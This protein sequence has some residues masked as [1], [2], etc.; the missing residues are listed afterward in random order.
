MASATDKRRREVLRAIVSDYIASQEPVG[1]KAL[2]ERHELNVSSATIRNDMAV[3][4]SEGFIAQ[5]HASSGR[6]PTEKGYREFVNN[7][8]E[9]KPLSLPERRAI[10]AFLEQ[11]VDLEDV[12]R[13]SVHLLSQLTRQVA[14]VQ[15]PNLRVSQVKHCE[16]VAL[17]PTR[18]LIVLITDTG[19]VDQRNVEF[20]VP[21]DE[22]DVARIGQM[23]NRALEG[24]GF[25]A[26]SV[27][28]ADLA[29]SAPDDLSAALTRCATVLIETLVE[30]PDD[31][32]L[33]AGTANLMRR[34][35]AM[36]DTL[37]LVLDALEEQVVVLRLFTDMS[38][39]GS[40]NVIIG[41]ENEDE[42]FHGSSVVTTAYGVE[43]APLGGMGVVGP[44]FMDYPG[45]IAKISAVARYVTRVLGGR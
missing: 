2:L 45:T 39:L 10:Q 31:K 18:L 42:G 32:L 36:S 41:E 25:D 24:K 6:I 12:L 9:I 40:V 34:G 28:L 44:T 1:S 16:V 5:Q 35:Y 11:G 30:K 38:A 19:R 43:G 26:A 17:S 8:H 7:I 22:E 3:L 21:V 27:A 13:R 15:L 37:P 33:M 23:L 14:M 29:A 20:S 4:E